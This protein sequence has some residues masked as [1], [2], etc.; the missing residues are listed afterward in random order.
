MKSGITASDGSPTGLGLALLGAGVVAVGAGV[1]VGV[2]RRNK[3]RTSG[4]AAE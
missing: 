1:T 2:R 4:E 3:R